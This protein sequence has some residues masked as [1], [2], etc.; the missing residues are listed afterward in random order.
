MIIFLAK[1]VVIALAILI[2]V[3]AV[4]VVVTEEAGLC[5]DNIDGR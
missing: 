2:V 5:R 4:V 1:P 3:T